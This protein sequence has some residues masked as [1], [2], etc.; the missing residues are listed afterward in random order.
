MW[1]TTSSP[2][3]SSTTVPSTT[4]SSRTLTCTS[5]TC[6]CMCINRDTL[7]QAMLSIKKNPIRLFTV[8]IQVE[9]Q[10]V[11][12][13]M[14]HKVM[15][16]PSV[17]IFSIQTPGSQQQHPTTST[18]SIPVP[19]FI[20]TFHTRLNP[21]FDKINFHPYLRSPECYQPTRIG[22]CVASSFLAISTLAPLVTKDFVIGSG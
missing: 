7:A 22:D 3:P 9:S 17:L 12:S 15:S 19:C 20:S 14:S 10:S 4:T 2:S 18:G 11:P 5:S 16:S 21:I 6:P 1:S 13:S 8:A